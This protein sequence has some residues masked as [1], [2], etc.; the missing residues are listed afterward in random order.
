[1]RGCATDGISFI[2]IILLVPASDK[3]KMNLAILSACEELLELF[4]W[5]YPSLG[6]STTT[7]RGFP[8]ARIHK[9]ALLKSG[10]WFSY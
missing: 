9:P 5:N 4:I 7:S 8:D 1:M 6:N 2:D 3:S 10:L